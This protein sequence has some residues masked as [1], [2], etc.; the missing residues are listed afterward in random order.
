MD[1]VACNVVYVDRG[2][3]E[4]CVVDGSHFRDDGSAIP[5]WLS[6]PLR[7]TLSLLTGAFGEG[8]ASCR[9]LQASI[10]AVVLQTVLTTS[11]VH[12]CATGAGCMSKLFDHDTSLIDLKPTLVLIDVPHDEPLPE[13]SS[14]S[15]STSPHS[16]GPSES[17]AD[18]AD[19][20]TYGLRLLEKLVTE[21]HLRNLSKLVVP[22]TIVNS[23]PS[24]A[25]AATGSVG[26]NGVAQ[27]GSSLDG[28][29][30]SR[31]LLRRCLDLGATDVLTGPLH[32][33]Q[34]NGLEV[35]AY[36]AQKE[37]ARDQ[38]TLLE[39]RRGRQRSWV[40]VSEEKPYAYLRE[41]M[42]SGLMGNICKV[43]DERDD[44][45]SSVRISVSTERKAQIA[46]AIG[47]WYFCA[48]DFSD[49]ELV[50]A[51]SIM[52]K[53]ALSMPE[54]EKWRIPTGELSLSVAPRAP[55]GNRGGRLTWLIEQI[56]Y[57]ASSSPFEQLTTRSCRTTT[58]AML[59]MFCRRPST[60]S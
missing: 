41:S 54:L 20:E 19:S 3:K 46:D 48:H 47:K 60:S 57:E 23:P 9:Q 17:E 36:R 14:W 51:S 29:T 31:R 34:L 58:F 11:P 26:G 44:R 33:S 38:Q 12:A 49:D 27:P 22:I 53:H 59:W 1:S 37:A 28:A 6:D 18:L 13:G 2:V 21:A 45:I 56:N 4:D 16:R 35:H 30:A 25:S 8:K 15:R 52:F 42:V 55:A 5:P 40:G 24:S 43:S 32:P 50:V 10:F 39:I 7:G